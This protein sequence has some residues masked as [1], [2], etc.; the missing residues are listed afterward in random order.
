MQRIHNDGWSADI[1]YLLQHIG[2]KVEVYAD[3]EEW[4]RK[5][6]Q[7]ALQDCLM[8]RGKDYKNYVVVVH[9]WEH[10]GKFCVVEL[11]SAFVD[12]KNNELLFLLKKGE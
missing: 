4:N 3:D 2:E 11:N 12:K 1:T 5:E 9:G 6:V 8:D 10:D 7:A